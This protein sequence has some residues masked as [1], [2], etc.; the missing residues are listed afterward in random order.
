MDIK[1]GNT[2]CLLHPLNQQ[3]IQIRLNSRMENI[4][5]CGFL[6]CIA[7]DRTVLGGF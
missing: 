5:L 3:R 1:N 4:A 6:F 7:Q 2:G